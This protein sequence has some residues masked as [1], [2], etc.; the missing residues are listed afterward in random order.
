VK[1]FLLFAGDAY[2]P[3]SGWDDL[4]GNYDTLEEA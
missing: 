1:Q 4:R 3:N 2:Y